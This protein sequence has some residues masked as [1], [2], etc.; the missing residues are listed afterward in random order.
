MYQ[1][2]ILFDQ[3]NMILNDLFFY[4]RIRF[5]RKAIAQNLMSAPPDLKFS[6]K[7][8]HLSIVPLF[9]SLLQVSL[10]LSLQGVL[11][12][13]LSV[14]FSLSLSLSHSF[15]LQVALFQDLSHGLSLSLPRFFSL[16]GNFNPT[17]C[18]S[19]CLSI[20]LSVCLSASLSL[21]QY[22]NN[23]VLSC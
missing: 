14:T 16:S 17:T 6:A 1:I 4:H 7:T 19:V 10:S 3:I 9:P 23:L 15:S 21:S 18:L 13:S 8:I 20:C 5:S 2:F 22:S 12:L 11:C